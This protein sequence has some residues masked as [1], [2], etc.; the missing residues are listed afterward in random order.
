M[1]KSGYTCITISKDLR[2]K[3][4]RSARERGFKS[5]PEFIESLIST[6]TNCA[7]TST[8][9]IANQG[10]S[11]ESLAGG[12]GFEPTTPSLG[13]SCPVLARLPA[14]QTGERM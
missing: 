7:G 4:K 6:S 2:D 5:T 3:L 13:G 10:H 14:Q 11:L 9:I 8:Q 12:G 1:P